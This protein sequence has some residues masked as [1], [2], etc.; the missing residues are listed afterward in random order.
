M[1]IVIVTE[2]ITQFSVS[3]KLTQKAKIMESRDV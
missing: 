3:L 1:I 2:A